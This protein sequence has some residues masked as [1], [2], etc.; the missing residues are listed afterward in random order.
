LKACKLKTEI[1]ILKNIEK[2]KEKKEK[3]VLFF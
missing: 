2:R 3:V 1:I